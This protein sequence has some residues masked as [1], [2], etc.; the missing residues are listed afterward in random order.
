[1]GGSRAG[2]S[3]AGEYRAVIPGDADL[4]VVAADD[5]ADLE[6]RR[7]LGRRLE[8]VE[9]GFPAPGLPGSTLALPE[10]TSSLSESG[11]SVS[12]DGSSTRA[13]RAAAT[14]FPW[15]SWGR[16]TRPSRSLGDQF[17]QEVR[18]RHPRV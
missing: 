6:V 2:G 5:L 1:M 8:Q 9:R 16:S 7:F 13:A 4:E 17:V 14:T 18:A 15:R 12:T 11:A 10:A 3:C